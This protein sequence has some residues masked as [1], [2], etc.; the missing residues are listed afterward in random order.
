MVKSLTDKVVLTEQQ[1]NELRNEVTRVGHLAR[2]VC[3]QKVEK[4]KYGS[5]DRKASKVKK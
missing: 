3:K 5:I 4:A 2:I 1:I